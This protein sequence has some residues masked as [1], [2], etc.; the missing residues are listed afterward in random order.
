M[1]DPAK[2]SLTVQAGGQLPLGPV[3]V[4]IVPEDGDSIEFALTSSQS[5]HQLMLPAGRYGIVARRPNGER[6]RRSVNLKASPQV[7]TFSDDVKASPNEFMRL[8]TSRGE[9]ASAG[10]SGQVKGPAILKGFVAE[11]LKSVAAA[12]FAAQSERP[13]QRRGA[14]E[15]QQLTIRAWPLR[16]PA[17][18]DVSPP[19]TG[20]SLLKISVHKGCLA[21]GLL[22][23]S[24]YGPIVMT[25]KFRDGLDITFLAEG[26]ST[27]A[28]PRYLNPSGQRTPVA[29]ATPRE[30]K[31]ADLLGA[32]GVPLVEHAE[33]VWEQSV[34]SVKSGSDAI[35]G[36]LAFLSEKFTLPGEALLAAH[37]L[38]RF[39]PDRLPLHWADNLSKAYPG[40]ADGPVI[41]AWLRLTGK[42]DDVGTQDP[43][44]IDGAVKDLLSTA[45]RSHVVLFARTRAL[46]ADGL[47]LQPIDIGDAVDPSIYL[48][49]GAHAGGLEAFWGRDT[50]SPG[51]AG[52]QP[53]KPFVNLGKVRLQGAVFVQ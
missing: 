4:E 52:P 9:V 20:S 10:F 23:E 1:T 25:P 34:G 48:N 19:D 17:D 15:I 43:T 38:L 40:V 29:L 12:Q 33:A 47:R 39:L 28:A 49:Y 35:A 45:L 44:Q 51:P 18:M 42:G 3:T 26:I 16:G 7:V 27:W 14:Q 21:V 8:E 11:A 13:V 37:Y 53:K 24:G 36:S 32:L 6:L 50:H 30:P 5:Q 46:L 31:V 2:F 41:S 22:D